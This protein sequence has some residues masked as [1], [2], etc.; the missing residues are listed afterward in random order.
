M[1]RSLRQDLVLEAAY[2][3]SKGTKLAMPIAINNLNSSLLPLGNAL[4]QSVANP[5]QK[6]PPAARS[7]PPPSPNRSC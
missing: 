1:Q 5:F 6:Y 4:L 7:R 3:G 2:T